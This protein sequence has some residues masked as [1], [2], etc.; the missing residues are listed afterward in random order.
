MV[1]TIYGDETWNVSDATVYRPSDRWKMT[2][3]GGY[4]FRQTKRSPD[5]PERYRDFSGSL[6]AEG[7]IGSKGNIDVNYVFDQY[8]KS[9]YQRIARLDI[10]GYSNV[11]NSL[12]AL[13]THTF[14]AG[15]IL[16]A[17]ADYMHDYLYNSKLSGNTRR[18]DSFDALR[19]VRLDDYRPP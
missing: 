10:R 19:T 5:T 16:S 18:Q 17:G 14:D 9:D 2:A 12:R 15:N 6:R 8:D 7:R 1:S 4:F 3:R 13:Y 11:Q